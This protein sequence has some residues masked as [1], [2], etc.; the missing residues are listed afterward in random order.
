[1]LADQASSN[2]RRSLVM[3]GGL[4]NLTCARFFEGPAKA[5]ELDQAT[6]LDAMILDGCG[7]FKATSPWGPR[8]MVRSE[9]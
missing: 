4:E 9:V 8:G 5:R 3:S 7:T 6:L 2:G 1:M